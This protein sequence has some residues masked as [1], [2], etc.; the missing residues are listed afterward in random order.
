MIFIGGILYAEKFTKI[1][2]G[3]AIFVFLIIE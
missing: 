2:T 3:G 1:A